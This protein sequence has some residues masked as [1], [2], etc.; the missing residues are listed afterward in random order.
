M[1]NLSNIYYSFSILFLRCIVITAFLS[2][3]YMK[4]K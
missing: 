1:H 3:D 4:N 2:V